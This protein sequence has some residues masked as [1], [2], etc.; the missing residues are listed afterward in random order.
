MINIYN[1]HTADA[2][3][4]Y[5]SSISP[6]LIPL[7]D[8]LSKP[9]LQEFFRINLKTI[10]CGSPS[11]LLYLHGKFQ[12]SWSDADLKCNVEKIKNGKNIIIHK[13]F[14]GYD[15]LNDTQKYNLLSSIGISTCPYCNT[16]YILTDKIGKTRPEID[17][18]YPK[19]TFPILSL[20]F[21]NLIPSCVDCNRKKGKTDVSLKSFIHPYVDN[22]TN[23]F[24][25]SYE[26]KSVNDIGVKLNIDN[27]QQNEKLSNTFQLFKIGER[28]NGY[29]QVALDLIE[30]KE[31]YSDDYLRT[32]EAFSK[33]KIDKQ[34]VYELALGGA[35][36]DAEFYRKPFSKLTKDISRQLDFIE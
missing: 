13:M 2:C 1:A 7:I 30:I 26:L 3:E 6:I 17:H 8:W 5:Y 16:S 10:I 36:D 22:I 14:L 31:M 21:Y 24:H 27:V 34:K 35:F 15:L 28:Y 4:K 32:L 29:R 18:Y 12:D 20:S 19:A 33:L 25:F 23:D 9:D 11:E